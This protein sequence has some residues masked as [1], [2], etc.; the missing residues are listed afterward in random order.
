MRKNKPYWGREL[1]RINT[2]EEMLINVGPQHERIKPIRII[3]PLPHEEERDQHQEEHVSHDLW[4]E[5]NRIPTPEEILALA[6]LRGRRREEKSM[7]NPGPKEIKEI[8]QLDNKK[9]YRDKYILGSN[10]NNIIGYNLYQDRKED[11]Q[12]KYTFQDQIIVDLYQHQQFIENTNQFK[13]AVPLRLEPTKHTELSAEYARRIATMDK[14]ISAKELNA[15]ARLV[16]IGPL[17]SAALMLGEPLADKT[18]QLPEQVRQKSIEL[19]RIYAATC[20]PET[21]IGKVLQAELKEGAGVKIFNTDEDTVFQLNEILAR[22]RACTATTNTDLSKSPAAAFLEDSRAG[23]SVHFEFSSAQ[24]GSYNRF[25]LAVD[26]TG[27][28]VLFYD[29]LE[30][31]NLARATIDNYV[32]DGFPG[33][34]IASFAASIVIAN[35][36]GIGKVAFGELEMVDVARHLGLGERK[37]FRDEPN[38]GQKL[39]HVGGTTFDG[40][41]YLWK[42]GYDKSFR[43]AKA[44]AFTPT[45]L[46]AIV[47][48]AYLV[49]E[50]I[51]DNRK[52]VKKLRTDYERFFSIVDTIYEEARP[53]FGE[54]MYQRLHQDVASFCDE[55]K[56]KLHQEE[57]QLEPLLPA[58]AEL[59]ALSPQPMISQVA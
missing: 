38:D 10:L 47:N 27:E 6:L 55:Y 51:Q 49:M 44:G 52:S 41:H 9:D 57:Q 40:R 35:R 8:Y 16:R 7:F 50:R 12:N 59:S 28:P 39:G 22:N 42:M 20:S 46:P 32:K 1:E 58:P 26:R 53:L 54:T 3:N 13:N 15:V 17:V 21:A 11:L 56:L 14:T 48:Q 31:G 19:Q 37:V 36:L 4:K 43:T 24:G 25:Y 34:L 23:G 5:G 29:C 33:A 45:I 2:L 30:S 18:K